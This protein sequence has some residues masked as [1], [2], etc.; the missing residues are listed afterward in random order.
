MR[1]EVRVRVSPPILEITEG[2]GGEGGSEGGRERAR[3]QCRVLC[4]GRAHRPP[5]PDPPTREH[6][7]SLGRKR[8]PPGQGQPELL[9]LNHGIA[10]G[11]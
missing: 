4:P 10:S 3:P 8:S 9:E 6:T 11:A 1:C 7:A 5:H 2:G